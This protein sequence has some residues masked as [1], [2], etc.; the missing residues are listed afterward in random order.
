MQL[1]SVIRNRAYTG[2]GSI[3]GIPD[4]LS[5]V[6]LKRGGEGEEVGGA[7]AAVNALSCQ[8]PNIPVKRPPS[9]P[10]S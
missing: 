4:T 6:C 3:K 5:G 8:T 9:S 1:A 2:E 7:T 10:S